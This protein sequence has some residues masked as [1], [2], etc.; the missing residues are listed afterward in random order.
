MT[1]F[2]FTANNSFL[3]VPAADA[4]PYAVAGVA[5]D[6]STTNRSGARMGPRAIRQASHMLCD[7]TH[8]HFNVS[9]LGRLGDVGDLA[10]AEHWPCCDA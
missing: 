4:Q 3:K 1:G 7:G 2:A 8:P 9:P 6:G 10:T 5:W